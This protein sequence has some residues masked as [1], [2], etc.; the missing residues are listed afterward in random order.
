MGE[1]GR[2]LN[3]HWILWGT[4]SSTGSDGVVV[5]VQLIKVADPSVRRTERYRLETGEGTVGPAWSDLSNAA[6]SELDGDR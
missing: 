6:K 5:E 1:I 2:R 4:V 3:A